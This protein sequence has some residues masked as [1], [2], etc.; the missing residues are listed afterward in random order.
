MTIG[1]ILTSKCGRGPEKA[2]IIGERDD[3]YVLRFIVNSGTLPL[4]KSFSLFK[5]GVDANRYGWREVKE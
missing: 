2:Q 5:S 3:R 1:T 4:Y